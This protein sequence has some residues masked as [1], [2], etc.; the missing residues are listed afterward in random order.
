MDLEALVLYRLAGRIELLYALK[1]VSSGSL[2]YREASERYGV[3]Q[4][5]LERAL[6]DVCEVRLQACLRV[7]PS[8]IDLVLVSVP[9]IAVGTTCKLCGVVVLNIVLHI[10][11]K[12]RDL[13]NYYTNV[14]EKE[15]SESL[16]RTY[17][18][19]RRP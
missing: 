12:H 6:R 14:L 4:G 17:A 10:K 19:L 7:L 16:G 15:V 11:R 18:E 13:L 9:P 8:V 5:V 3:S 1:S 2:S